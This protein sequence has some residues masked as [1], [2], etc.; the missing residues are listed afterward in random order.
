M[1]ETLKNVVQ[2]NISPALNEI[3]DKLDLSAELVSQL[4]EPS[5]DGADVTNSGH[6]TTLAEN[7]VTKPSSV[8]YRPLGVNNPDFEYE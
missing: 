1:S 6:L 4:W 5:E 7:V 2:S 8:P 3:N